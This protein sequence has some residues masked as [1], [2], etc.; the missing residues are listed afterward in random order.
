MAKILIVD[1]ELGIRELLAEILSGERH[2][3]ESAANAQEARQLLLSFKP[4]LVLLDIW[5]PDTDGLSLL[6][7]WAGQGQLTMP[8]IMMSGHASI[9]TAQQ[10]MKVGAV[11]FLEKPITW[12]K[13]MQA[14]QQ[15]LARPIVPIVPPKL[16]KVERPRP[17]EFLE[18]KVPEAFQSFALDK[19]LKEAREAFERAYFEFH[20]LRERF[21]MSKLA[22]RTGVERTHL[23]RKLKQ[24]GMD[25]GRAS[26]RA[27][28][29][30]ALAVQSEDGTLMDEE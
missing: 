4:Q 10:A 29:E 7:E 22:E 18:P 16:N 9:E 20:M 15:A 3:T 24:L 8:V 11:S 6:K 12:T 25:A 30:Q 19:P 5:M 26:K 21:N 1:D 2:V 17:A 27:A 23:Y 28:R 14:V 13:L